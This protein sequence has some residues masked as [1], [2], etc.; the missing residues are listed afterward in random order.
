VNQAAPL[1]RTGPQLPGW[2]FLGVAVLLS[3]G[4]AAAIWVADHL[5]PDE[6]LCEA[7]LFAHLASMVLGFGAVLA[8]DWVGLQW[9][10]GLRPITDVVSTAGQVQ[11]PI[12]IGLVGLVL[13]GILLEPDASN[14]LTQVKLGLVLLVTWNGLVA[15]LLHRRFSRAGERPPR[16]LLLLAALSAAISQAGWW[17]AMAIGFVN[18]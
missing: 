5:H 8:I 3:G 17:G 4:L 14:K 18:H 11:A 12:W 7:A 15:T 6:V 13:S 1:Q 2:S 10:L 9:V 16:L